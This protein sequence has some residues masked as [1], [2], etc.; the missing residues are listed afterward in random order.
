MLIRCQKYS[1]TKK[2]ITICEGKRVI[3]RVVKYLGIAHDEVQLAEMKALAKLEIACLEKEKKHPP[4]KL[5]RDLKLF[6]PQF[7]TWLKK[8]VLLKGSKIFF[9][10]FSIT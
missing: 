9:L 8:S 1:S 5:I 10:L 3:Q 2:V 6:G 4:F 7:K